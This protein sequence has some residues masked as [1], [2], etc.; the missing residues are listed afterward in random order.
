MFKDPVKWSKKM[1]GYN[2]FFYSMIGLHVAIAIML[3]FG[4]YFIYKVI[5]P[6]W[7]VGFVIILQLLLCITYLRALRNIL[8]EK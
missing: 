6:G 2:M 7:I 3:I 5:Q 1:L 4:I 8:K